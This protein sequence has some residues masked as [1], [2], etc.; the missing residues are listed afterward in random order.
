LPVGFPGET[1]PLPTVTWDS[2]QVTWDS[3]SVTWEGVDLSDSKAPSLEQPVWVPPAGF[4]RIEVYRRSDDELLAE[5]PVKNLS[6]GEVG[7]DAG[8]IG[9]ELPKYDPK[10]TREILE[11]GQRIIRIYRDDA[12]DPVWGGYL[13]TAVTSSG[14][15]VVRF[16]G[17]SWFSALAR[18]SVTSDR[19]FVNQDQLDIAW[20]LIAYTQA[21]TSG[22]L[23]IAR[24]TVPLSTILRTITYLGSER[25]KIAGILQQLA[26]GDDGFDFEVDPLLRWIAYYPRRGGPVD[27]ILETGKNVSDYGFTIDAFAIASNVSALGAGDGSHKLIATA[28][29]AGTAVA[30]GLME[31]EISEDDVSSSA[32]LQS[33]AD[34]ELVNRRNGLEIP[35]LTVFATGLDVP[36]GVIHPGDEP[37][38]RLNDG[39]AEIS[40]TF[41]CSGITVNVPQQGTERMVLTFDRRVS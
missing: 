19:V 16:G 30:Y 25:G 9:F 3:L 1:L 36:V 37:T 12:P 22:D 41:H 18:R 31:E 28:S 20:E 17:A 15:K 35:Q 10:C 8:P 7:N 39:Y 4:Y 14:E 27:F 21:K 32:L 29:D 23:G 6:W 5:I 38:L 2:Q 26:G 13:W 33:L 24:Q 11:P 34:Q 40:G